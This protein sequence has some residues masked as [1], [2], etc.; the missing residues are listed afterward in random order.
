MAAQRESFTRAAN[1]LN[2][3]QGA[4]SRHIRELE[5]H[6]G[7]RLFDRVRQRVILTE[8]GR[9]FLEHVKKPLDDL[10]VAARRLEA[11]TDGMVLKLA[12][13]PAFATRWLL[14]RLAGFQ[15][16]NG[17]ITVHVTNRRRP[18]DFVT[19]PFHAAIVV[20]SSYGTGSVVHHLTNMH[21]VAACSPTLDAKQCI[22]KPADIARFALL[23]EMSRPN[24]WAQ[25][26]ADAGVQ[27]GPFVKGHSYPQLAML[28]EAAVAGFGIALLPYDLFEDEFNDN[29]LELVPNQPYKTKISYDL[30]VPEARAGCDAMRTLAAWLIAEASSAEVRPARQRFG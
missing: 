21:L 23:H 27:L 4:V 5:G 18:V 15:K 16:Q 22:K 7:I 12:V 20:D 19:E 26:M 28:A 30:I 8:A 25:W 14:P 2:L 29:R 17:K 6:L 13:P 10:A 3:S 11:F 1:E 24:R 9:L